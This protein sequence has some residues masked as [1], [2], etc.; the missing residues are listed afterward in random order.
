MKIVFIGLTIS[1]SW[2]NGHATTYRGLLKALGSLGHE[3][4]FLEHDKPWYSSNRDFTQAELYQL[5]FYSSLEELKIK[6]HD[7]VQS[8]HLVVLGS[9]VPEGV[10]VAQWV[11]EVASGVTA[12]YDIDTPVTLQKL[13]RG[14]HE[15]LSKSVIPFFDLYLSFSGGEV[16][17]LLEEKYSAKNARALY[18]SVDPELYY[19]MKLIKS[20]TLGYLGTYSDDRQPPLE[21]LLISPA[22]SLPEREFIVAGPGYPE[23]I[24]WPE[25][26]QRIDHLPP[27]LHRE[28]YNQQHFTLNVTRQAMINLGYSPS[29]RLFEAAACGVPI[30]SDDWKGLTDLFEEGREIYIARSSEDVIAI[31]KDT[32]ESER[33][34][35]GEAARMKIL[36]SHTA[37]H[38]ALELITYYQEIKNRVKN[39]SLL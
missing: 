5:E 14:D 26:V 20:W 10:T 36:N 2:G 12:F 25:N 31:L 4:Y 13:D 35:V 32:T 33:K 24:L 17:H 34:K 19:P 1:S 39:T 9:Y 38:R 7:L 6:F 27:H 8:A 29:V 11:F 15:Y 30:I 23:N 18:C 21:N 28:F 22:R 3:V 37:V 16:L